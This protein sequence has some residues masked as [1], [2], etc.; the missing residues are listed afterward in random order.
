[1]NLAVAVETILNGSV[2]GLFS[3]IFNFGVPY[4]GDPPLLVMLIIL[5]HVR[6]YEVSYVLKNTKYE[7]IRSDTWSIHVH[8]CPNTQS[9]ERPSGPESYYTHDSCTVVQ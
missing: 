3:F 9:L 2:E 5:V 4:L 6:P 7:P 1:M 8:P